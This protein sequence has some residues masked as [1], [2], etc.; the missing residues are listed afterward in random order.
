M[1]RRIPPLNSVRAFEAAARNGS[2]TEA[3]KELSVTPTAI[4]HQIRYLENLLNIKLFDRNGRNL[5]LT[6]YGTRIQSDV[7]RGF[8]CLAAAFLDTY[9]QVDINSVSVS[10][11]REF[12]RFWLLPRAH[13]FL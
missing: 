1:R 12:A 3:A 8:D 7:S 6:Q 10:T 5:S 2:F 13:F 9:G 4:S 11:T